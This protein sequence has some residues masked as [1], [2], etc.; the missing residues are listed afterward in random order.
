MD[1]VST[2]LDAARRAV[3]LDDFGEESFREGLEILV[4]SAD[5]HARF[6]ERGRHAFDAQIV[7]FLCR[8]LEIEHWYALRPEIDEQ[9]IAAPLIGLGLPRTGSTA[10]SCMLAEDPAARSLRYWETAAPCPPPEAAT[11]DA[12]PR[13]AAADEALARRHMLIPGL[14]A[15]LPLSATG[16]MECQNFMA[17]DFKS[18]L[19]AATLEAPEYCAWLYHEADLVPTYRYVKRVLKLLQWRCPPNRWRLKNPAHMMFITALDQVF[20]DARFWMTHR[21]IAQ[22]IASI[23]DMLFAL[24]SGGSDS[25]DRG[26][27]S[28]FTQDSWEL[29]LRR[30]IAFR[31][32]GAEGRF[33]DIQFEAFQS[34]PFPAI[35]GLYDFVGEPLSAQAR[36]RMEAWRVA[37]PR[38]KHGGRDYRAADY[39]LEPAALRQ[40]FAFYAERFGAPAPSPA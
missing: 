37:T 20:P 13:I 35:Q 3:S 40:R 7:G 11:Q 10:L 33:F 36:A 29:G 34:D 27:L 19:F 15:M 6:T 22:V 30:L 8:R 28:R 25:V 5:A 16:P 9:E 21:D 12:D 18:N 14:K 31:D 39:G 26:Y 32:G 23:T 24:S 4:R 1:R 38:D 2:L 17:Y